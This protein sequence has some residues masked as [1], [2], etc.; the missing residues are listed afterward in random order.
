MLTRLLT[1]DCIQLANFVHSWQ[2]SIYLAASPLVQQ[3]KI[4][5]RYVE[6]MIQSIE[7]YGPY[8]IIT[9][10]VAIPH[11]RPTD[12]V[13]ELGMSLLRLQKPVYFSPS[14]PVNLIIVLA[15]IDNASHLQALADLTLVLQDT[16]QIDCLIAC[17]HE[18]T[19]WEKIKQ[20]TTKEST[21]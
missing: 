2:E 4:E 14:Q 21:G 11:A 1:K 20:Y 19:I 16:E 8:I 5:Q 3:N 17:Q 12:G 13:H 6:A 15:A 9:P 10:K 18:D 7:Q